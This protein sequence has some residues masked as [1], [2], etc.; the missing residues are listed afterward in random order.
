[1]WFIYACMYSILCM[2]SIILCIIRRVLMDT[3]LVYQEKLNVRSVQLELIVCLLHRLLL[4]IQTHR[5]LKDITV[6]RVCFIYLLFWVV[7]PFFSRGYD[8]IVSQEHAMRW[9]YVLS[10]GTLWEHIWDHSKLFKGV[11]DY[12][13]NILRSWGW[14]LFHD[15][16]LF[17]P[18]INKC[19]IIE[20]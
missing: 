7:C 15:L 20:C 19:V 13:S 5:V 4:M 8:H 3:I 12:C 17:W 18:E 16:L 1:M 2:Y 14:V 9:I 10:T 11:I 6:H